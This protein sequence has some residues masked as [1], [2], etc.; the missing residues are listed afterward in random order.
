M[1]ANR[2][3]ISRPR[4]SS[5]EHHKI[6]NTPDEIFDEII[7]ARNIENFEFIFTH[8]TDEAL[9]EGT[10]VQDLALHAF[11]TLLERLMCGSDEYNSEDIRRLTL[12]KSTTEY[13]LQLMA[14]E[15]ACRF[16]KYYIGYLLK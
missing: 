12:L 6:T 2:W 13:A 5:Y 14:K 3:P 9:E 11:E 4:G 15:T 8:M 10:C 16:E 7:E 1:S